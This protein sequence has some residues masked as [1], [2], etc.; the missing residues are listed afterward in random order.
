MCVCV[1]VDEIISLPWFCKKLKN[2]LSKN[3]SFRGVILLLLVRES[4]FVGWGFLFPIV[5]VP[6]YKLSLY[7]T[8]IKPDLLG[9]Q[10]LVSLRVGCMTT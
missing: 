2:D 1:Y 3:N 10:E 4:I 8:P 7:H 6:R 9:F 5:L